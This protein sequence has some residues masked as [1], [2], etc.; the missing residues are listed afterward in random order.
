MQIKEYLHTAILVSNLE[1]AEHFYGNILGLS[2]VDRSLNF[3][4]TWYQVGDFQIHLIVDTNIKPQLHNFEKL[5]RNRH[6]A[7]SVSNLDEAKSQ[8]LT[9]SCEVQ[10][11]ASGRAALFTIDPDGNVIELNLG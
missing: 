3:P 9:H 5:G 8:L 11:S 4:G 10:M 1:R 2:Q 6:I 7:F